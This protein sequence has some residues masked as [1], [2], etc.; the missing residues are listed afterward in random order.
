[1]IDPLEPII[2]SKEAL[3]P[4][5]HILLVAPPPYATA[6]TESLVTAGQSFQLFRQ[7]QRLHVS[8]YYHTSNPDNRQEYKEHKDAVARLLAWRE[9]YSSN[10]NRH[11]LHSTAKIPKFTIKLHPDPE[12]YASFV[13]TFE[14]YRHSYLTEPY[15]AWRN[16]KAVMDRL[17]ESAHKL[18]PAPERLMIQ[19]WWDEFVGEMA[20]WEELLDSTLQLPT[21]EVVMGDLERMVEKA[22]DFEGEWDKIC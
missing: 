4:P 5:A 9:Q 16:A 2:F 8:R 19:S 13:S 11:T 3:R 10:P 6:I 20:G 22:V 7:L 18:L 12:T 14:K 17:M 21:F 15:L 1:M